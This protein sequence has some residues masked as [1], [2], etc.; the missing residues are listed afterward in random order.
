[1][2]T[3]KEGFKGSGGYLAK[4]I[5]IEKAVKYVKFHLLLG[6]SSVVD[7]IISQANKTKIYMIKRYYTTSIPKRS[8]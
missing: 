8:S 7:I 4:W 1:M 3:A 6:F 2:A 5:W